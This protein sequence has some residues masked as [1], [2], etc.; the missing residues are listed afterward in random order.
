MSNFYE[1]EFLWALFYTVSIETV[2]LFILIK[3]LPFFKKNQISKFRILGT[4]ILASFSTLPYVWF[5]FPAF[6]T[7]KTGFIVISESFAI[8]IETFILNILLNIKCREAFLL[9]ITCNI[10][11]FTAGLLYHIF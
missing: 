2:V 6:I 7:D 5:I 9:S 11:S 1:I 3:K 4:G 10:L 8:G